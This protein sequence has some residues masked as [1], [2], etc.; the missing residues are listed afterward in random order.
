MKFKTVIFDLDGTMLN[1]LEDLG[2]AVNHVLKKHGYP[3]KAIDDYRYLIGN[4]ADNLIK[5]AAAGI[6]DGP[7]KND[8]VTEF[9]NIYAQTCTQSTYI[10]DGITELLD[11]MDDDNISYAVLSNKPHELTNKMINFYFPDKSF[12][13]IIGE[14]TGN[15][16]KPDPFCANQIIKM[17]NCEAKE[18]IFLGDSGVDM[19]TAVNAGAFPVGVLWGF[20]ER[21]ELLDNGAALLIEHPEKLRQVI[22]GEVDKSCL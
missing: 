6:M 16:K 5:S 19:I 22:C 17:F 7:E 14:Q 3:E 18:T 15:P 11:W 10:Y 20:R 12:T 4:G 8:M 2:K 13:A 21:K 1:T 9:K